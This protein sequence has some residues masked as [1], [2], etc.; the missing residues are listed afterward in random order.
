MSAETAFAADRKVL[1]Q[2]FAFF[3]HEAEIELSLRVAL[4]RQRS[5]LAHGRHVIAAIICLAPFLEILRARCP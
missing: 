1:R 2:A 3:V 4:F 5:L